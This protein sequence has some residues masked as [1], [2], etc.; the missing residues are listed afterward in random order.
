VTLPFTVQAYVPPASQTNYIENM[1]HEG[2]GI[3]ALDLLGTAGIDYFIES[4]T[5]LTAPAA[6]RPLPGS[7]NPAPSPDGR[8][9]QRVTNDADEAFYRSS[10]VSP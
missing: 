5:S 1:T 9:M 6:W 8:W 7:T 10:P 4:S 2:A 3:F